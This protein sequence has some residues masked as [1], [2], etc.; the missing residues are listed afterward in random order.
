MLCIFSVWI[1]LIHIQR[2]ISIPLPQKS[3]LSE[4]TAPGITFQLKKMEKDLSVVFSHWKLNHIFPC[5][6][7]NTSGCA[8]NTN[9]LPHP[10]SKKINWSCWDWR[11]TAAHCPRHSAQ[12]PSLLLGV[13]RSI[14]KLQGPR[15]A[16]WSRQGEATSLDQQFGADPL[17][18]QGTSSMLR[19][20][21]S[22]SGLRIS[23]HPICSHSYGPSAVLIPN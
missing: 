14:Q 18:P 7:N 10:V 23:C 12:Q 21:G 11:C 20:F 6:G 13:R 22:C 19:C 5:T 3:R 8:S 1:F 15:N 16:D 4:T 17:P 2:C 9:L